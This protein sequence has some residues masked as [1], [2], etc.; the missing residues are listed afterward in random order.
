VDDLR[1]AGP[2]AFPIDGRFHGEPEPGR[3][4]AAGDE[5]AGTELAHCAVDAPL[6][7]LKLSELALEYPCAGLR[8]L[9]SADHRALIS[10]Q[11]ILE[12]LSR[13]V[14]P[15]LSALAE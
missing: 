1:D 2:G 4:G 5:H 9:E 11:A 10:G 15:P 13:H 8:G 14:P 3:N 7:R 12:I 6:A